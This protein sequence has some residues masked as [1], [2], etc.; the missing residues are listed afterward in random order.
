MQINFDNVPTSNP[1]SG[2]VTPG[3]Y[4]GVVKKVEVK[5]DK[6]NKD[7]LTINF[8][9]FRPDGSAAGTFSDFIRDTASDAPLYKLGRL[10]LAMG[11]Q[12]TGTLDLKMLAR[13]IP[14]G[15]EVAMEIADNNWQGKTTSQVKIFDSQCYWPVSM[16]A[17]LASAGSV[18]GAVAVSAPQPVEA[19]IAP[20][21]AEFP[22]DAA[23]GVVPAPATAPTMA[24]GTAGTATLTGDN[25]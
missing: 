11:I 14:I 6:N 12:L 10:L 8:A 7:Y 22:F 13:A 9:L 3:F 16:L 1:M 25:Y 19:P 20:N 2:Y 18:P 21:A 17:G 15:K 23:D 5:P 24:P 4:K